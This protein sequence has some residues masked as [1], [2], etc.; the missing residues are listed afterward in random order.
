MK[1]DLLPFYHSSLTLLE[2]EN[3][4]TELCHGKMLS[5]VIKEKPT[6]EYIFV[7]GTSPPENYDERGLAYYYLKLMGTSVKLREYYFLKGHGREPR[8]LCTVAKTNVMRYVEHI[9]ELLERILNRAAEL[10]LISLQEINEAKYDSKKK[11]AEA[12]TKPEILVERF[13]EALQ[14]ALKVSLPNPHTSFIWH[15]R[16]IPKKYIKAFYPKMLDEE[17]FQFLQELLGLREYIVPRIEDQELADLYTIFSYDHAVVVVPRVDF[18]DIDGMSFPK[19]YRK[20]SVSLY[21]CGYLPSTTRYPQT[22]GGCICRVN[23]LIWGMFSQCRDE[24]AVALREVPDP[25]YN[26]R[27]LAGDKRPQ[28]YRTF[29][30]YPRSYEVL[31]MLDELFPALF[32]GQLELVLS[33]DGERIHVY[34]RW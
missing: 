32:Y 9:G 19:H 7:G 26:W 24:L 16:K 20:P 8:T 33:E 30:E 21:L 34:E 12:L 27:I 14:N 2:L 5:E 29:Y 17:T 31:S 25:F 10:G 23:E 22:I 3:S 6:L 4:L 13:G 28:A 1:E 15:L 18:V 11:A